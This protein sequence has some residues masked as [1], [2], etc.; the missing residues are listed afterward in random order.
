[1]LHFDMMNGIAVIDAGTVLMIPQLNIL[2]NKLDPDLRDRV[3]TYIHVSSQIDK[4][5]PFF[6]AAFNEIHE[7][8]RK[9]YFNIEQP[10]PDTLQGEIEECS[11]VYTKAFET[12]EKRM[13][14]VFD[15]KLDQIRI[16]VDATE[17]EIIKSTHPTSGAVAFTSN[18]DI[19]TKSMG[20]ID[21]LMVVKNKLEAKIM[22]AAETAGKYRG[23]KRP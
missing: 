23:G 18:I 20:S 16:K 5:A 12:P 7:L 15:K 2:Y 11:A 10:F 22:N 6:S 21:G 9:N 1:M 4:N 3:F 17:P 8:C 19:I 14:K 13:L